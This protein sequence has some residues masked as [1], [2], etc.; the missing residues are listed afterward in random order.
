M[1]L[2]KLMISVDGVVKSD[3]NMS[4][5]ITLT[6]PLQGECKSRDLDLTKRKV[7]R[8]DAS[9]NR[10]LLTIFHKDERNGFTCV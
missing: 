2:L 5:R 8:M 9:V 1:L 3:Q 4:L 7:S 6:K 10:K